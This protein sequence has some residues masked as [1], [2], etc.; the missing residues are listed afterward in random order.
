M[1]AQLGIYP[2]VSRA[3][4]LA[5]LLLLVPSLH[6][7]PAAASLKPSSLNLGWGYTRDLDTNAESQTPIPSL[8]V[9]WSFGRHW[10]IR[11]GTAYLRE[12]TVVPSRATAI[13][14][15]HFV[16]LSAG[17]RLYAG[18]SD[19]RTR[20][21]FLEAS[22]AAY[23]AWLPVGAGRYRTRVVAGTIWGVG[24]RFPGVDGSR[25]EL[26]LRYYQSEAVGPQQTYDVDLRAYSPTLPAVRQLQHPGLGVLAA[27]LALGLGDD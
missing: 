19:E 6:A 21:L 12:R 11:S 17:I 1:S 18:A 7:L 24:V 3:Q 13:G 26:G 14:L 8:D 2:M 22:P 23:L 9:N 10:A 20:G 4:F 5:L 15:A 27:Y 16:P 25:G